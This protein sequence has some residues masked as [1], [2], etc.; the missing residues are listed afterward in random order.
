MSVDSAANRESPPKLSSWIAVSV[1]GIAWSLTL[2]SSPFSVM[3]AS[4][5]WLSIGLALLVSDRR[6]LSVGAAG[7]VVATIIA[8]GDGA[9]GLTVTVAITAAV[10]AWDI[11]HNAIGLGR[12]LGR[13][14]ATTEI[15]LVHA[16]T[17]T[18]AGAVIVA[19]GAGAP[20]LV[21]GPLSLVAVVYL[22]LAAGLLVVVLGP[23][24]VLA[25]EWET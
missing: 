5:G 2:S 11:G 24:D 13:G 1:A 12:Q 7:I 17:S 6:V 9:G 22:L 25:F 8:A 18:A 23:R 16:G 19:I 20:R 21:D 10:L 4:I 15:E 3:A 14:A